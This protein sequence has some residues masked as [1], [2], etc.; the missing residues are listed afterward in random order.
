MPGRA[1]RKKKM[2]CPRCNREMKREKTREHSFVYRCPVC[3]LEIGKRKEET[4]EER[5]EAQGKG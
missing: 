4:I 1:E 2:K 5:Q 3:G